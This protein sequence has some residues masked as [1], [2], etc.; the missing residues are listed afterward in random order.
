MRCSARTGLV[1]WHQTDLPDGR[2]IVL[3]YPTRDL[4][5]VFVPLR[6]KTGNTPS[7]SATVGRGGGMDSGC[8]VG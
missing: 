1:Q 8:W 6:V 7:T 5:V 4:E 2:C 3:R